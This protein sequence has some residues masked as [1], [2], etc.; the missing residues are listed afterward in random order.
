MDCLIEISKKGDGISESQLNENIFD[1]MKNESKVI[2]SKCLDIISNTQ[3][4]KKD[5]VLSK[6]TVDSVS[7]NMKNDNK[8]NQL[9]EI[10]IIKKEV[11]KQKISNDSVF[12]LGSHMKNSDD[13]DIRKNLLETMKIMD[14]KKELKGL[15]KTNYEIE[16]NS[17]NLINEGSKDN[18]LKA[19]ENLNELIDKGNIMNE[20]TITAVQKTFEQ[21]DMKLAIE[22]GNL[23]NK[24]AQNNTEINK[25]CLDAISKKTNEMLNSLQNN[26][27]DS[28]NKEKENNKKAK[29]GNEKKE[30][31]NKE[32]KEEEE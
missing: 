6:A 12:N 21:K 10:D 1:L 29:E 30:D 27:E 15:D 13:L 22:S 8:K 16:N 4:L 23:I 32:V 20:H 19:F 26:Q 7:Q 3:I 9:K 14:Q 2:Q 25:D 17:Y 5:I 24:M 18:K 11:L 31:N 28:Q